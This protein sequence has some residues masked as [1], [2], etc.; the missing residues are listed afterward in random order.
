[1]PVEMWNDEEFI[2]EWHNR[3]YALKAK[4]AEDSKAIVDG[5][6]TFRMLSVALN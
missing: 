2:A 6:Y 3:I 4:L 1:M 5:F